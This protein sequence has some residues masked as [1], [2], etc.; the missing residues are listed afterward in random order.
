M[1]VRVILIPEAE[2]GVKDLGARLL[3]QIVHRLLPFLPKIAADEFTHQAC[4]GSHLH[5]FLIGN[6]LE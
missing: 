6:Q 5:V 3:A 2:V 1:G 4:V